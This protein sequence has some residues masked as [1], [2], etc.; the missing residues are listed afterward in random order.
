[1]TD[2]TLTPRQLRLAAR[3]ALFG[4]V[5]LAGCGTMAPGYQRPA[6]PVAQQWPSHDATLARPV[7]GQTA[8]P[9][10]DLPGWRSYFTDAHLQALIDTSLRHNRDVRVALANVEQ[11]RALL[12]ARD[13]DRYPTLNAAASGARTQLAN[14][15]TQRSYSV[16]LNVSAW[17]LDLFGRLASLSEVARAQFLASDEGRKAASISLI[18]SV[19]TSWLNLLADDALLALARD[20]VSSREATLKLIE[21]R[22]QHGSSGALD[23]RQAQASLETARIAVVQQQRQ[24]AL[25]LNALTLLLGQPAPAGP[26]AAPA[27][28]TNPT[29]DAVTLADLPAGLPSDVLTQRPDIRQA[30]QHLIAAHANIGAARAA[31]FPRISLTAGYGTVSNDL[32]RLFASGTWGLSV[33]PQ[34]LA[35]IFDAGRNQAN[36]QAAQA[37]RDLALAQYERA[38]QS[39][40]RE[41]ADALTARSSWVEQLQT[42]Q[43]LLDAEQARLKLAHLRYEH[44]V[45]SHL[46]LLDAQRSR[47]AAQ[48]GLIQVRLQRLLNQVQVYRVLGGGVDASG[49][50][51][52]AQAGAAAPSR[53]P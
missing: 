8:H 43:K 1:M 4:V 31:F 47:F 7:D 9:A 40:F 30:E 14:G 6:A 24:R 19:A 3:M 36:L 23:L 42:Q 50:A 45:T 20:T 33:A 16:G 22:V 37:G 15:T 11:A 18:A 32:A 48:Q 25:N 5:T 53:A 49:S 52:L 10:A 12:D 46:E 39:G 51:A 26:A 34:L 13:A 35:P 17:E 27:A 2:K 28:S 38:I 41:V 29:L 44:G 21:L